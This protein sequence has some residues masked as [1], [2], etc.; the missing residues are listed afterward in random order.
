ML[1]NYG[2]IHEQMV[3]IQE[4]FIASKA[5]A[6]R[7]EVIQH[8]EILKKNNVLMYDKSEGFAELRFLV[9]REDE[10]VHRS[11][12]KNIEARNKTK[13]TQLKSMQSYLENDRICRNRQLIAYFG[14]DDRE[15]CGQC[16]VC[17]KKRIAS[18]WPGYDLAADRIKNLLFSSVQLD[19]AEIQQQLELDEDRLSKTLEMMVEKKWIRLNL[20]NKFELNE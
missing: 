6:S 14:E 7:S 13:L 5:G 3:S 16:D 15:D 10:F 12:A 17:R 9:P 18:N 20:Q 11:T 8:L 19:F 4:S 2:G 1:R